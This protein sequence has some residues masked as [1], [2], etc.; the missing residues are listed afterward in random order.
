MKKRLLL[1]IVAIAAMLLFTAAAY[2]NTYGMDRPDNNRL[3]L[4]PG[5]S[6]APTGPVEISGILVDAGCSDRSQEN[7]L[8]APAQMNLQAPAVTSEEAQALNEQR[9]K[10][11]FAGKDVQ[12]QPPGIQAHGITIDK[13]TLDQEQADVL[14]HQVR[15]LYSRQPDDSCGITGDT[16]EFALLTDQGRLLNLDQGGNSWA[17]QAVQSSDEGRALLN[18]TGSPFKPRVTIKG[19]I[20]T[21]Q[22][23]VEHLTL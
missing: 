5:A 17:W 16:K 6:V 19:E 4:G 7:L 22:L 18:G 20:W 8:R 9:S 23:V 13:E 12:P 21:D 15:D 14:Q 1:I 11:G 3:F 2:K 10:T